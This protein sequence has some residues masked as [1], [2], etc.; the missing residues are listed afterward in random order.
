MTPMDASI[1]R[2]I[3]TLASRTLLEAA[4]EYCEYGRT[5]G[6][7][8]S[9]IRDLKGEWMNFLT[10]GMSTVVAEELLKNE[11]EIAV[12]LKKIEEVN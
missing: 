3:E 1:M 5:E 8:K 10:D 2:G 4:K 11:K 9:I 6:E 12:R 7:K